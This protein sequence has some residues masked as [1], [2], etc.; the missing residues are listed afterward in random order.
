MLGGV[1][2][3][4]VTVININYG[5]QELS[6]C[7]QSGAREYFA[8]IQNW[9]DC[10][11]FLNILSLVILVPTGSDWARAFGAFGTVL[12]LPKVAAVSRGHE[13]MSA[14]V[15]M[16]AEV[17]YDMVP[18][19]SLMMFVILVNSFSFELLSPVDCSLH[20]LEPSNCLAC[21]SMTGARE[22]CFDGAP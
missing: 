18:F 15:T 21:R 17:V 2:F 9:F 8:S 12:L 3:V 11:S 7:R 20:A 5:L 16:L 14:L 19:L 6:E 13:K 22:W 1:F 10:A 4:V